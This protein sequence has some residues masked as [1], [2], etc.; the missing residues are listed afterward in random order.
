MAFFILVRRGSL[1]FWSVFSSKSWPL[2]SRTSFC[3]AWANQSW[4]GVWHG[5]PKRVLVEQTYPGT[6]DFQAHF[7]AILPAFRDRR[8]L[9]V[10]G[11]P[12][13]IVYSPFNLPDTKEF[14]DLWNE[15]ALKAGLPGVY[16][17]G[18]SN[19]YDSEILRPFDMLSESGARELPRQIAARLQKSRSPE[20]EEATF[21]SFTK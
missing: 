14:T 11:K 18:M 20:L 4:S 10:G 2:E 15:L 13:F 3:L 1:K 8:Y 19:K 12:I 21:W 16:F 6:A 17:V 5:N 9:T 7:R